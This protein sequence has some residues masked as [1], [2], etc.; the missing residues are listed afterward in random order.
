[1]SS[2]PSSLVP[3]EYL[4]AISSHTSVME[5]IP[6]DFSDGNYT[7]V[8]RWDAMIPPSVMD[9]LTAVERRC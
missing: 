8:M 1:M 7:I 2:L 5:N 9:H 4:S 3:S 6:P